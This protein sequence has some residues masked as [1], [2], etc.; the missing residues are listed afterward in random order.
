MQMCYKDHNISGKEQIFLCIAALVLSVLGILAEEEQAVKPQNC[1][2][3]CIQQG[4]SECN[5]CRITSQDTQIASKLGFNIQDI[6]GGCIPKPCFALMS[7]R[8]LCEHYVKAPEW[9]DI[10]FIDTKDR[11]SDTVIIKWRPSPSGLSFLRGFQISLQ[12]LRADIG[13]VGCQLYLFNTVLELES[14]DNHKVY[15]SDPFTGLV[16]NT[17]YVATVIALP[18]PEQWNHFY[19]SK[20]FRTRSCLQMKKKLSL[21]RSDWYPRN[22]TISQQGSSLLITFDLAPRA[23]NVNNYYLFYKEGKGNVMKY[24]MYSPMHLMQQEG[25][26]EDKMEY[27]VVVL[28]NLTQG[29]NYTIEV[30]GDFEDATRKTAYYFVT[31]SDSITGST[32]SLGTVLVIALAP[33]L[34]LAV[35]S[36]IMVISRWKK[37]RHQTTAIEKDIEKR[38]VDSKVVEYY[39]EKLI[40]APT[41]IPKVFICYSS[42]DGS[43]HTA[44]V[45]RFAA[46]LQEYCGCKV[47]LD[48][49]DHLSTAEEGKMGWMCHQIEES[50]YILVVCSKGLKYY[51]EKCSQRPGCTKV[52]DCNNT[53]IAAIHIIAEKLRQAR[54]Y[55]YDISKF[56]AV[57]FEYSSKETVP[58][59]LDLAAKYELMED[60]PLLFS[61][62]HGLAL[63]G[64]RHE[65]YIEN[66][67]K[68]SYFKTCS[69]LALYTAITNM[70]QF[71][72]SSPQWFEHLLKETYKSI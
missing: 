52:S 26:Q 68:N 11:K 25:Q 59:I 21:C 51:V 37:Q 66:I 17:Q 35:V 30:A 5:F 36:L 23:L 56:I 46:Y 53:F 50:D 3:D 49:W 62:L 6:F 13:L 4:A 40:Q 60:F 1:T 33:S 63:S 19:T 41:F 57:F 8:N 64:P 7:N 42:L 22:I 39:S 43:K 31:K 29:R 16:L 18:V 48:I 58:T 10:Q 69:G 65:L 24:V 38:F 47:A 20:P 28:S 72:N 70:C 15:Q 54:I 71:V 44:V 12:G 45:L 2:K 9:V 55:S 61:H 67:S 14:G 34:I 27:G 32:G